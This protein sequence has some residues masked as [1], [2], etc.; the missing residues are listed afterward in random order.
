MQRGPTTIRSRAL[1]AA[2]APPAGVEV[3]ERPREHHLR[4]GRVGEREA[5][6]G[7]EEAR[8]SATGS[9]VSALSASGGEAAEAG[10]ED[11]PTSPARSPKSS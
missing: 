9:A 5:A 4:E 10:G 1:R 7:G 2:P 3:G 8:R 11:S 6:E